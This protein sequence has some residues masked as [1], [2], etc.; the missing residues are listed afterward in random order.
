MKIVIVEDEEALSKVLAEKFSK[1][2]F[3]TSVAKNGGEAIDVIRKNMPDIIALDL[4]LPRKNGLKIL[5]EIKADPELKPIPVIVLSNLGEDED[6]KT[7]LRLGAEDYLVKSQHPIN[8][9]VEKFKMRLL[10]KSK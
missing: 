6:I 7:A 5:E 2:G 1:N 8:E 10:S 3:E 4:L 9:V